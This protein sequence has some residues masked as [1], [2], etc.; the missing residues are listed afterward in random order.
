MNEPPQPGARDLPGTYEGF[1]SGPAHRDVVAV[2][3]DP[4]RSESHHHL[5]A[6]LKEDSQ[7][8]P[9]QLLE[10]HFRYVAVV[11]IQPL[12]PVGYGAVRL[13]GPHAFLAPPGSEFFRRSGN[14]LGD[15]ARR[16]VGGEYQREPE[17]RVRL[18]QRD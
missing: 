15:L 12:V 14:A 18:M 16:A 1:I 4:V 10:V 7:D 9:H 11:V 2:P 17:A 6:F 13:P 5:R 3:R 8:P